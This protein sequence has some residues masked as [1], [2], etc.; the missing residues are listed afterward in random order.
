MARWGTAMVVAVGVLGGCGPDLPE[1][2]KAAEPVDSLT[3]ASCAGS[4]YEPHDERITSDLEPDPLHV[5]YLRAHFRCEQEVEAFWQRDGEGVEVLVQPVDMR[6][7]VVA[8]CDCLYDVAID[9]AVLPSAP[10]AVTLFR[11]WDALNEPNPPVRIGTVVGGAACADFEPAACAGRAGCAP[12]DARPM[13]DDGA[14]GV[15]VDFGVPFQA[16]GC[17]AAAVGCDDV[18]TVATDP[19]GAAWWFPSSCVPDGWTSTSNAPDV[20]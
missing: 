10:E 6:P 8:G 16:V 3:Q 4:P 13:V 15:C 5:D 18:E 20:C 2:W 12:I 7:S 14:G 19:D 9:V 17:M 1:G 11:R